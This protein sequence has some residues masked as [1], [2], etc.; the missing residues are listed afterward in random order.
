MYLSILAALT[1]LASAF[2]AG[3]PA[4]ELRPVWSARS[5]PTPDPS[6]EDVAARYGD[7][8]VTFAEFD[9]LLLSRHALSKIGREA[10]LF[11]LKLQV[12]DAIAGEEG[13]VA[14]EDQIRAMQEEIER[15]VVTARQAKSLAEY[16]EREGVTE[17]EFLEKLRLAVLQQTLA[18]R[19]LGIPEDQPI[20][21]EQQEM[22][23]EDA[24]GERELTE[25]P[26][27]WGKGVLVSGAGIRI[28][29][30]EF[31]AF[32]RTR[33]DESQVRDALLELLLVKRMRERMPDLSQKALDEA[34]AVEIAGRAGEVAKDP[35]YQGLTYQQLLESQGIVWATWP[36]DPAILRSA[37]AKLWVERSYDEAT[38]RQ[39][40]EDEREKFDG[41]YGEAIETWVLF[42]RA[43]RMVNELVPRTYET[44][45][46]ELYELSKEV[47]SRTVFE[48]RVAHLSENL[49]TREKQGLLGWVTRL[50][51]TGPLPVREAIFHALDSGAYQ[52]GAPENA[53][54]RLVGPVRTSSGVL[55]LWLGRRRPAP[56]WNTMANH[57]RSELRQDFAVASLEVREV[58]TYLDRD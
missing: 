57:V 45:E 26:A 1:L 52:P 55:L 25:H 41:L 11:L 17:E 12:I 21:S 18:R 2:S 51:T 33:L 43:G 36:S 28:G 30:D 42:L 5:H 14:S 48:A 9:S 47:T 53:T 3:G 24:I 19:A 56:S 29:R 34:I 35:K 46:K 27:P 15:G 10:R 49:T 22:W 23:I 39:L 50:G 37:L 16:L 4:V 54:T 40:Y 13:V 6:D 7:T 20:S 38:L 32:L 8:T 44:A 31:L 58:V